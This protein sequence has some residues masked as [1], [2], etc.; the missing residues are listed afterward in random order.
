MNGGKQTLAP[1]TFSAL[2]LLGSKPLKRLT[3]GWSACR[4][5]GT[6]KMLCG[7][8]KDR[9]RLFSLGRAAGMHPGP[10]TLHDTK[11][12]SPVSGRGAGI[13]QPRPH[14]YRAGLGH[15]ETQGLSEL[16][17]TWHGIT[18]RSRCCPDKVER[19]TVWG[20]GMWGGTLH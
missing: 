18:S 20:T 3:E 15:Q 17:R 10:R 13:C 6:S 12:R 7:P 19:D 1:P 14:R 8:Q 4:P 2:Y 11:E 16:I 9:E 5:Q